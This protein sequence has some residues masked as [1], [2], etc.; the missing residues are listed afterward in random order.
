MAS[1]R[2]HPRA[3]GVAALTCGLRRRGEAGAALTCLPAGSGGPGA[4]VTYASEGRREAGAARRCDVCPPGRRRRRRFM[5]RRPLAGLAAA[6]LG[7]ALSD[8][9]W[10]PLTAGRSSGRAQT[11]G[12]SRPAGHGLNARR[13]GGSAATRVRGA[14][15]ARAER[16]CRGSPS[17]TPGVVLVNS[18]I[19]PATETALDVPQWFPELCFRISKA[20]GDKNGVVFSWS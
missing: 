6:A 8:G 18:V 12:G 11:T 1:P 13:R 19:S 3:Q 14:T 9:E 5:L 10:R 15:G 2:R 4:A 20:E 7:R 17:G 16:G